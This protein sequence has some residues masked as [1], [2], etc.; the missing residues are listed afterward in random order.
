MFNLFNNYKTLLILAITLIVAI[1]YTVQQNRIDSQLKKIQKQEIKINNQK[2]NQLKLEN[3][4][5]NQKLEASQ[6]I[7]LVELN[8][9][10]KNIDAK[11]NQYSHD[12]N[13]SIIHINTIKD[14]TK[15]NE[16]SPDTDYTIEIN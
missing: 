16:L 5:S 2:V 9:S 15:I 11:N 8:N 10:I 12:T 7:K 6:K 14:A 1:V 13:K 3:N 4:L